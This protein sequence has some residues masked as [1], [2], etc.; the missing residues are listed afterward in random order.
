M[1]YFVIET[2]VEDGAGAVIPLAFTDRNQAESK[3]HQLLSACA[4]SEVDKHGVMLC[5]EDLFVIKQEVYNH[6]VPEE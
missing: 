6:L 2:Q 5:N 3:Y 4:V 1:V